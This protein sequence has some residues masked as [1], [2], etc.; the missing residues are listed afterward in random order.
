MDERDYHSYHELYEV[1][2]L[3]LPPPDLLIYL[4]ASVPTLLER[5][6]RRG[7]SF[8]RSI[9]DTYLQQL[10]ALYEEWLERFDLCPVLTVPSDDLDF[11]ANSN[12]LDLIVEK[13]MEKLQ[14][15]E[16]VVFP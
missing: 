5:I 12:H 11:V 6:A 9:S 13:M 2:T 15:R 3:L 4:R 7:R 16:E 8:E 10:S 1:L 14:G